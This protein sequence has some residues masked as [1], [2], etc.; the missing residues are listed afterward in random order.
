MTQSLLQLRPGSKCDCA[1]H[2][3]SDSP[4]DA[5][6]ARPLAWNSGFFLLAVLIFTLPETKPA[7]LQ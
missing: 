3:R 2:Y 7:E 6:S 4:I 5:G 1:F